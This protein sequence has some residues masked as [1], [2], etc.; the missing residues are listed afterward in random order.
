M[1]YIILNSRYSTAI[2][3]EKRKTKQSVIIQASDKIEY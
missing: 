3:Y 2:A 1:P